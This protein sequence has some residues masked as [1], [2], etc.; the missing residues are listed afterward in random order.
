MFVCQAAVCGDLDASR[1][2]WELIWDFCIFLSPSSPNIETR[3]RLVGGDRR[4]Q[5]ELVAVD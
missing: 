3:G 5:I 4:S 1:L 2:Q